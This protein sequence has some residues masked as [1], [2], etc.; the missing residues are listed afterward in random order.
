MARKKEMITEY[1]NNI[2]NEAFKGNKK[3]LVDQFEANFQKAQNTILTCKESYVLNKYFKEGKS[4][5]EIGASFG[6]G[7]ERTRQYKH[8]G[9]EKLKKYANMFETGLVGAHRK[10]TSISVLNLEAKSHN[11]LIKNNINSI[12]ELKEISYD[13]LKSLGG[14]GE[15]I[16]SDVINALR[17]YDKGSNAADKYVYKEIKRIAVKYHLSTKDLINII[18]TYEN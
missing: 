17:I 1:P 13:E 18:N 15:K 8:D 10:Y 5:E 12:E 9:I 2:I 6:V 14:I 16:A 3:I 11:A 7:K 4:L